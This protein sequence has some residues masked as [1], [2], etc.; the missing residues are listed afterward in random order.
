MCLDYAK[1]HE[2]LIRKFG[3][4]PHRN[5]ILGREDTEEEEKF[6]KLNQETFGA[7]KN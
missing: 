7:S 6:L 5:S 3:R 4:F 1:K 2:E